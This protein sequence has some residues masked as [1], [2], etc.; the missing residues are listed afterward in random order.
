MALL[1]ITVNQKENQMGVQEHHK[2]YLQYVINT[3]GYATVANFDED[4]EPIGPMLRA[5][6][7][8]EFIEENGDGKLIL[9]EAGKEAL[10]TTT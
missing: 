6:L 2:E 9:T 1:V 7:M 5:D 3:G 10:G 8:P 4:W